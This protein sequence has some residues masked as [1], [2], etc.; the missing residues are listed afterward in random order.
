MANL[1]FY[2][3]IIGMLVILAVAFIYFFVSGKSKAKSANSDF[4]GNTVTQNY[5][6]SQKN[7]E[8]LSDDTLIAVLT[9]AV[10][11]MQSNPDVKIKVTSFRRIPQSAPVWNTVGRR[12]RM[13]NKL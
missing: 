10:M 5:K 3:I 9:A 11:A 8:D 13:E 1:N 12:E 4:N 6:E 7:N 2:Q